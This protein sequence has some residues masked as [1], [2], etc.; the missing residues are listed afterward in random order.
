MAHVLLQRVG[1]APE[2]SSPLD[3]SPVSSAAA[4]LRM[5]RAPAFN[6]GYLTNRL[7]EEAVAFI[8]RKK[9]KGVRSIYWMH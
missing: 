6:E 8:E 5:P 2:G 4:F 1:A 9:I 7:S 3:D